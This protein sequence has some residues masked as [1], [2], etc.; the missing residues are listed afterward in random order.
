VSV[1]PPFPAFL[2][3]AGRRVLVVGG[4]PVAASRLAPLLE[5]GARVT[6]VA[7][8]VRSEAVRDGV[9]V[10]RRAFE[11]RDLDGVWLA[12]AAAPPEVN[13]QVA[14]AAEER[15]VFVNAVDDSAVA[16]VYTAGVFRRGEVTIAVS[17]G[18]AAPALAGLLR[19]GLEAV[20]PDDVQSWVKEARAL[21]ARQRAEGV[22][23]AQRRPLLLEALN[24]I[25]AQKRAS[26]STPPPYPAPTYGGRGAPGFT[27]GLSTPLPGADGG[28]GFVS[29][30]G[31][32]PGDPE[33]LTVR[34]VR[35]LEQADLVLYDALV[36]PEAVAL[37]TH[38]QRFCVGKRAGRPSVRQETID[39]LMIRGARRGQRV[40]RLK[41][42]D[43]FVLGRGGEEGLALAAAGIPFEVV[44]GLTS[45]VVAPAL[46]GIPVTHRGIASGF[47]VVSGH[48]PKAWRPALEALEPA[49]LTV[50]V[51]MG[52]AA[53]GEIADA[54]VTRGW[55]R[56]T[57]VAIAFD[58]SHPSASTWFGTL[59]TLPTAATGAVDSAGAIVI[60]GVV[61]LAAT[62]SP[63]VSDVSALAASQGR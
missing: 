33:L 11:P 37:A 5:A 50:V 60:G 17:T 55:S 23:M 20:V 57:P 31:A 9:V 10:E 40:V 26:L 43:P 32:G 39:A 21:K 4:G 58:A 28:H 46:A 16:S 14:A 29:L 27:T 15:R 7:P 8:E 1:P 56:D 49:S 25:Y 51:L 38:A 6:L 61:S 3:L 62:L 52:L 63:A 47:V 12:V 34:A 48:A 24:G 45:A 44:P 36:S 35:R 30:V 42:G 18:G 41:C 59:E 13:R 19:E 2:K 54:L 53:R 22:P